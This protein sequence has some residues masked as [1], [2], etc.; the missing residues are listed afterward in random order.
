MVGAI[1]LVVPAATKW[2]PT[3][4]PLAAAVLAVETLS[5]G[6]LQARY[7]RAIPAWSAG[8]GLVAA[9]VAY[10]RFALGPLV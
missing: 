3:L 10:G 5:L 6:G 7:S 4:T 9:F 2:L 1:L 8:M